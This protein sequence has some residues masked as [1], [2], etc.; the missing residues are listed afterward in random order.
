MT[1]RWILSVATLL[2]LASCGPAATVGG[3]GGGAGGGPAAASG[4]AGANTAA[5][6]IAVTAEGWPSRRCLGFTP[7]GRFAYILRFY[8]RRPAPAVEHYVNIRKLELATGSHE[9]LDW[10]ISE[11]VDDP[12]VEGAYPAK[13]EPN[14]TQRG[15]KALAD[16]LANVNAF[17]GRD[18]LLACQESRGDGLR[19]TVARGGDPVL[20]AVSGGGDELTVT[21]DGT[22]A[23][24]ADLKCVTDFEGAC[25]GPLEVIHK[26]FWIHGGSHALVMIGASA[27]D[28]TLRPVKI[29]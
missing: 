27:A 10:Y 24:V 1:R 4:S 26:V 11:E 23:K 22:T 29:P 15:A 9:A 20:F 6:P 8:N 13:G 28:P 3:R 7:D 16:A 18:R 12:A 5:T 21:K 17:I 2:A 25:S 14:A 19:V